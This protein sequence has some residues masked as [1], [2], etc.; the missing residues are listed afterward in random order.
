MPPNISMIYI[1]TT[2]LYSDL[3]YS[4]FPFQLNKQEDNN[5]LQKIFEFKIVIPEGIELLLLL[6]IMFYF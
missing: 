1:V 3:K 2:V 4:I 6:Q 5:R